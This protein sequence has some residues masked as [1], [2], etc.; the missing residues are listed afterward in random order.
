[1]VSEWFRGP[2]RSLQEAHTLLPA[3]LIS[4][5][6]TGPL[7]GASLDDFGDKETPVVVTEGRGLETARDG[8][9]EIARAIP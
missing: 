9:T 8:Q 2:S 1:M 7:R 6:E 4:H 3:Q 5:S